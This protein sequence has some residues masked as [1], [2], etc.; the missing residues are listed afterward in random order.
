MVEAIQF[1]FLRSKFQIA[2][3]IKFHMQHQIFKNAYR[4]V[5]SI[6]LLLPAEIQF[7]TSKCVST[8]YRSEYYFIFPSVITDKNSKQGINQYLDSI[9]VNRVELSP[10]RSSHQP[11]IPN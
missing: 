2:S 9:R 6:Y 3:K 4:V 1:N 11:G 7:S 8:D 5:P 10:Q